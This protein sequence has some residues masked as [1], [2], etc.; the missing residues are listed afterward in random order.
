[1][2]GNFDMRR[3]RHFM[4]AACCPSSFPNSQFSWPQHIN[5]PH[6]PARIESRESGVKSVVDFGAL[7]SVTDTDTRF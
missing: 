4:G 2:F 3:L 7:Q 5:K 6:L 1:M